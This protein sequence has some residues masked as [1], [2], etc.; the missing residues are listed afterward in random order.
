MKLVKESLSFERG[1]S[2]K[3]SMGV[4]IIAK[5]ENWLD[6]MGVENYTINP[7]FTINTKGGVY[8]N[9]Y[10]FES[11]EFPKFIQFNKINGSFNCQSSSLSTLRGCPKWVGWNFDCSHNM[12]KS[13]E[14]APSFVGMDFICNNNSI[15]F[16]IEDIRKNCEFSENS[17]IYVYLKNGRLHI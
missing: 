2:P 6:H 1:Q 16:N 3:I 13:L 5:I 11:G 4:G 17:K 8:L 14:Y 12:L 10:L 7:D 9:H 15:Q